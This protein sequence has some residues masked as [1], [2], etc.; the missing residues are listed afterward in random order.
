VPCATFIQT[1]GSTQSLGS[2]STFNI[3]LSTLACVHV[4]FN[5]KASVVLV[6]CNCLLNP[7]SLEHS[8]STCSFVRTIQHSC[9]VSRAKSLTIFAKSM[10][11][12]SIFLISLLTSFFLISF[13]VYCMHH[14]QLTIFAILNNLRYCPIGKNIL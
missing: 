14:F 7:E 4:L 3:Q 8:F 11:L 9:A 6:L 2:T 1:R 10:I 13:H 12:L 5:K